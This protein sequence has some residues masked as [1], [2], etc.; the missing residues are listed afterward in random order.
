MC[1]TC[2]SDFLSPLPN[3]PKCKIYTLASSNRILSDRNSTQP[4]ATLNAFKLSVYV[5]RIYSTLFSLEVCNS[6]QAIMNQAN[7]ELM[8]GRKM[9]LIRILLTLL[10]L[11]MLLPGWGFLDTSHAYESQDS[12]PALN[13]DTIGALS[14]IE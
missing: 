14:P 11:T 12:H 6:A 5:W 2:H 13:V 3:F 10:I 4:F 8:M 1:C 7:K 9:L